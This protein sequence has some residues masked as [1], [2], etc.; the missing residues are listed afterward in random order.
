MQLGVATYYIK[1]NSDGRVSVT[2]YNNLI[3]LN[4]FGADHVD[5]ID[6]CDK[7]WLPSGAYPTKLTVVS[8]PDLGVTGMTWQ[9]SNAQFKRVGVQSGS[10]SHS[11]DFTATKKVIGFE[12]VSGKSDV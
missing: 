9:F 1:P 8:E 10:F 5:S 4:K 11:Y 6:V 7:Y 3:L 2:D 12:G